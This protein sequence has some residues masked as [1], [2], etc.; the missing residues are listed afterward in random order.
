MRKICSVL[1]S[2]VSNVIDVRS[3]KIF[4]FRNPTGGG[5]DAG[6]DSLAGRMTALPALSSKLELRAFFLCLI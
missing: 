3:F 6:R 2:G 5:L 1:N 4:M